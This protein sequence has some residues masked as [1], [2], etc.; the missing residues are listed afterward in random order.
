MTGSTIERSP[1]QDDCSAR[2]T[3]ALRQM[4]YETTSLS[5]C[6][7]DGSHWCK[8]GAEALAQARAALALAKALGK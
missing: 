2:L 7:P 6:E 4:V 5:P 8:I 1:A 3:V